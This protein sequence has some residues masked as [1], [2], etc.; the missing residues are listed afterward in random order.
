M[1]QSTLPLKLWSEPHYRKGTY[2]Q[3]LLDNLRNVAIPGTGVPLHLFCYFKFTAFLFLLIVQPTIVF[4][5]TLNLY[6]FKGF[7]LEMACHEYVR[8][9]LGEELDWCSKWRVNCNVAAMHSVRTM[10][11]GGYD[12]E[13]K[14]AFLEK[15]AALGVPV[16]PIL[17]LPGLC[18]KHK[19]EEGGMGIHFYKNA[20]E[21]GDWIIQKVISNSSFVQSL[22]P[23]DAPLSTFR[24]LTQSRAATK[25]GPSGWIAPPILAD[26]EALSCVFRAGRKGAL[27]D[28]DSILF[29]IDPITSVILGGTTNANWYKLG[30]REA[31]PG[32]CDWRSG[33]EEHVVGEHPDKKGKKVKGKKV[34]E[35][36]AMLELCCS[37]H[38]SM[39][40]DVPFVGWDVVLCPDSDVPG[41]MCIL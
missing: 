18:I 6:F 8:V 5:A 22:L 37:S 41:G 32:G 30:L 3:D 39:C 7:N 15:G 35:L 28:H 27:T 33:D 10:K 31:L 23:D 17:D 16:S 12:M 4:I 34:K 38:L 25:V 24:I 29:N 1:Y 36:P 13:N 26:I 14:W 21:G 11:V 19:N 40:P 9:L 20:M 2:Q